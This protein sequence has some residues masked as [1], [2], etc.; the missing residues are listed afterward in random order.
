MDV[1]TDLIVK[2]LLGFLTACEKGRYLWRY[3]DQGCAAEVPDFYPDAVRRGVPAARDIEKAPTPQRRQ[4]WYADGLIRP[5]TF[6]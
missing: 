1:I 6:R 2:E 4:G 5:P 3:H